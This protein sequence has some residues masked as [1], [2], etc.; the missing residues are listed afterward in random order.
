MTVAT[1]NQTDYTTQDSATYKANIDADIN[2]LAKLAEMFAPRQSN[3]VGDMYMALDPGI[4]T[5]PDGSNST[6]SGGHILGPFSAPTGGNNRI[7]LITIAAGGMISADIIPG[8]PAAN[9]S[10]PACPAG[11][12]P[13]A[14]IFLSTGMNKIV[15]SN[16]TDI[17]GWLAAGSPAMGTQSWN[18]GNAPGNQYVSAGFNPSAVILLSTPAN[19]CNAVSVGF[20]NGYY[21]YCVY[22]T[23]SSSWIGTN[24]YSIMNQ[25]SVANTARALIGSKNATG[26]NLTW[27]KVGTPSGNA[28]FFWLA[29]R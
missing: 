29:L 15:N 21:H 22:S 23:N 8:T 1:F 17:R 16:I 19:Q 6:H 7:D 9:P 11:N 5:F 14:Q 24:G 4:L 2:V 27:D 13:I 10:P 12:L 26:F 20:D 28:T 25:P 3:A 18:M